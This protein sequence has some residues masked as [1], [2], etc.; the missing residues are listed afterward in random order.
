MTMVN[1]LLKKEYPT[2]YTPAVSTQVSNAL[3]VGEILGQV[4]VGLTCDYLG[5]F[6]A[7]SMTTA[8][9]V[10]GGILATAA[11]GVTING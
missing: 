9:I 1:V 4:I 2:Q 5:R 8:I 6:V 11:H 10:I 7:I 3:L